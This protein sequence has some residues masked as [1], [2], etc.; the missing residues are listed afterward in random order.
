[1]GIPNI[2]CSTSDGWNVQRGQTHYNC[3][4]RLR[5]EWV[6]RDKASGLRT[7]IRQ[8]PPRVIMIVAARNETLSKSSKKGVT[9]ASEGPLRRSPPCPYLDASVGAAKKV[10][11]CKLYEHEIDAGADGISI[12]SADGIRIQNAHYPD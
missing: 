12:T 5:F 7:Q 3:P 8:N 1:M 9:A 4:S 6:R 2:M 11:W 10:D